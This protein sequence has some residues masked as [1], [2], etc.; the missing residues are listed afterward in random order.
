[1]ALRCLYNSTTIL[2]GANP[3]IGRCSRVTALASSAGKLAKA[4]AALDA[5][6]AKPPAHAKP[7]GWFMQRYGWS[8][9]NANKVMRRKVRDGEWRTVVY[10]RKSYYWPA[11]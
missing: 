2:R 10:R 7:T 6:F 8:Q 5:E 11:Q 3:T 9:A 1:M 4:L